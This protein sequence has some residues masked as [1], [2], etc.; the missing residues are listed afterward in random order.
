MGRSPGGPPS[1]SSR[2]RAVGAAAVL[3][4]LGVPRDDELLELAD[5][6]TSTFEAALSHGSPDLLAD[7]LE[8]AGRRVRAL[9]GADLPVARVQALP[10]LLLTDLRTAAE[11]DRLEA[12]LAEALAI[13][14]GRPAEVP[15]ELGPSARS[16]LEHVLAGRREAAIG[17]VLDAAR[18]GTDLSVVLI[19]VL[20]ATQYEIGRRWERG[21]VSV[22]QEHYCTA[23]TQLA[24]TEL[25]PFLFART[26]GP[27]IGRRRP[28][29][30]AAQAAG[31]L[32]QVGLR[33]V[34]DLLEHE[35]W[36]TTYLGGVT[37][38]GPVVEA[39][40]EQGAGLLAVSASMPAHIEAVAA[41]IEAVRADRRTAGV[42]V[43]VG[44]R[45]FL[46]AP[47]LA[48]AVGADGLA[49]DAREAVA[50]C[51]RLEQADDVPA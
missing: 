30:V 42:R 6:G 48:N 28:R 1:R 45:P 23:V 38:P 10:R 47:D 46:V 24:M 2:T 43:V 7:F 49:R 5:L 37:E 33:M 14:S 3:G 22:A 18:S 50:V 27:R 15:V 13:L 41:I 21:E 17:V 12:F 40:V 39:L 32:H 44:G 25:Y 36:D 31:S 20:E 9:T 29:L 8:F 19:D 34:V 11:V 35:G 26:A 51:A 4:H 16:Y